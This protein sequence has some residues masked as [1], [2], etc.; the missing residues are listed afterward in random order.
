MTAPKGYRLRGG[1]GLVPRV[2]NA[3]RGTDHAQEP[4][5]G[6]PSLAG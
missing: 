4:E 2:P 1:G 6:F 3:V 5:E